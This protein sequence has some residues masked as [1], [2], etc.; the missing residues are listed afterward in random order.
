[1]ARTVEI[2]EEIG[3]PDLESDRKGLEKVRATLQTQ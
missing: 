3:H 1:M 2:D